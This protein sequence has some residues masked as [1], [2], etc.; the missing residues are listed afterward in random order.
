MK[1]SLHHISILIF[2]CILNTKTS[3]SQ[4]LIYNSKNLN[5]NKSKDNFTNNPFQLGFQT[6]TIFNFKNG[7]SFLEISYLGNL[8]IKL[9]EKISYIFF[10]VGIFN[11]VNS[12]E[13][14][15]G[16]LSLGYGHRFLNIDKSSLYGNLGIGIAPFLQP[17]VSL[18]YLYSVNE[19][20]G[21]T[22]NIKYP[23][24]SFQGTLVSIGIQLFNN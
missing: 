8:N 23:I 3:Y 12:N 24:S 20:V 14:G 6:G 2:F 22:F 17:L 16:Y 1:V 21:F 15:Q 13:K 4:D 18:K 9:H 11:D 10:E 7:S 5:L 19:I